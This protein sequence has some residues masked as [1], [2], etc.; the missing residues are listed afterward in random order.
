MK[1]S[2]LTAVVAAI[3][4]IGCGSEDRAAG[5]PAVPAPPSVPHSGA[6]VID[7]SAYPLELF[8]KT[9]H[10]V[11]MPEPGRARVEI[12]G[13]VLEGR[14]MVDCSVP[15]EVPPQVNDWDD[16][17][18]QIDFQVQMEDRYANVGLLRRVIPEHYENSPPGPI[19]FEN[20]FI[21]TLARGGRTIDTRHYGL[22]RNRADQAPRISVSHDR[23]PE[24]STSLDAV[25]GLRIHPDGRRATFVGMMGRGEAIEDSEYE[26]FEEVRI[27][28]HCGPV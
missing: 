27:A 2:T 15:T 3:G 7:W 28:V 18:L 17:R 9:L 12:F 22:Q 5:E 11:P 24:P 1:V 4:L 26:D 19:E 16:H 6:D 8:S 10:D 13:Q 20:V 23:R 25:P 14:L 21:R